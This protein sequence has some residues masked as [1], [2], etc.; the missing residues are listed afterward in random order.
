[1]SDMRVVFIAPPYTRFSAYMEIGN[2]AA[3]LVFDPFAG[4]G[5]VDSRPP[6]SQDQFVPRGKGFAVVG[7]ED[8]PQT[9]LN[10]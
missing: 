1:M 7:G 10:N 9:A 4:C 3:V 2:A 6:A 8:R 5:T